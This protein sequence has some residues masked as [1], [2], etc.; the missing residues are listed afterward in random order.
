MLV[1]VRVAR[2]QYYPEKQSLDAVSLVLVVFLCSNL[3]RVRQRIL[4]IQHLRSILHVSIRVVAGK[5]VSTD[6]TTYTVKHANS[7]RYI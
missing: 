7:V 1:R 5:T 3:D 6:T 4:P 2:M